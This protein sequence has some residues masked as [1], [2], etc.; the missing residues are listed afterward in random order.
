MFF[1]LWLGRTFRAL[2]VVFLLARNRELASELPRS[3][4][5]ELFKSNR[6]LQWQMIGIISFILMGLSVVLPTGIGFAFVLIFFLIGAS[7]LLAKPI[8]YLTQA[9]S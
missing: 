3:Y 7:A 4:L 2:K 1:F 9:R 6:F 8:Y 5:R